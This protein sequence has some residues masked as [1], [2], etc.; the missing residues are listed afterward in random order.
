MVNDKTA[1]GFGSTSYFVGAQFTWTLFNGTTTHYRMAEQKIAYSRIQQ[2]IHYQ[3]EQ[4]QLELNKTIRQL[5][6]EV[7]SLKHYEVSVRQAAEALRIVQNRFH[8]GLASV[9]DV[10]RSQSSLSEQKLLLAATVFKYNA[11]IAYLQFLSS[12]SDKNFN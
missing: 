12:N 6:D 2:Q 4:S 8:Q 3:K 5:T 11:T 1:F 7:S 10:L 9:D